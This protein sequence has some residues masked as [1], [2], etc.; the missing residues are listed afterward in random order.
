[1]KAGVA[2]AGWGQ[3]VCAG[4]YDND[5]RP[6]LLIS[7]MNER[8]SPL[9]N[10]LRA[11]KSL[12]L[13]LVGRKTNRSAIGAVARVTIGKRTLTGEVRSGST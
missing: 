12:T 13:K 10:T 2:R 8:L 7:N 11:G 9:H 4:D 5:G 1:M 3:G 6:D